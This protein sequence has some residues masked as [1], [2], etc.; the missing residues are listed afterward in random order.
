MTF[1]IF[2]IEVLNFKCYE[3]EHEFVF[4]QQPGLYYL[5]GRNLF[6][7]RLG[8]N[9][10]GKTSLIDALEWTFYGKTSRGL[11]AS[12]VVTWGQKTCTVSV[13]AM[14]GEDEVE[15]TRSQNP[16]K[17]KINGKSASQEEVLDL[18]RLN[19]E[20]F[21]ASIVLPQFGR[22]FFDLSPTEK[23]TMFSQVMDLDYWLDKSKKASDEANTLELSIESLEN[24]IANINGKLEVNRTDAK[25]LKVKR[26]N[27]TILIK[28]KVSDI[29]AA[30]KECSSEIKAKQK[31]LAKLQLK[32]DGL[33]REFDAVID[34]A[35]ECA[36][37]FGKV[38]GKFYEYNS[39]IN[40]AEKRIKEY[41]SDINSVE[42]LGETC[43]TCRQKITPGHVESHQ[44]KIRKR[45]KKLK[46]EIS[47]NT[48]KIDSI[49]KK[50]S[51][52]RGDTTE[53]AKLKQNVEERYSDCKDKRKDVE[54]SIEQHEANLKRFD[55]E[56]EK[57]KAQENPYEHLVASKIKNIKNFKAK[58]SQLEE[59][60][61]RIKV[62][63]QATSFWINGFK[64]I[65]LFVIEEAL[66]GLELEVN[67]LLSTL[68]LN[69]W[70]ITFDIERENKSG[71]ITKGFSV[72]IHSPK[73]DEPV[74]FESWSGGETQ[75]LRLAGDLGLA[76]LIMEQ[77]G[78]T[79][80]IELI[81]EPSE[82]MSPEGIED[83]IETIYQRAI[84]TGKQ[85][86]LADHNT[87]GFGDFAG[88][89][90]SVMDKSGKAHLE[91]KG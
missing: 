67:N 12:D 35:N 48:Q 79:N 40:A 31:Q 14:V 8:A 57:V 44:S 62:K 34:A 83:M 38:N 81:D 53:L 65:R 36:L 11:R 88:V 6:N 70:S 28:K 85:I 25:E 41:L 71:G 15:I 16:N 17:I 18:I 77:A 22:S 50:L 60:L 75:R 84:D 46:K 72:F 78:F 27:H 37:E 64:R 42:K 30:K 68:G 13:S 63:H 21:N 55:N 90:T 10:C 89:L 2:A 47:S 43:P 1:K 4:P 39:D 52:L 32:Q 91:Y 5:T 66:H 73:H 51:E 24:E 74:R 23:L 87:M 33:K 82:H 61:S 59:S 20:A 45:I 80:H 58:I 54:R 76:N 49:S 7:K 3:G 26:D 9:G 29:R 19:Q 86:W 69:D 56:I